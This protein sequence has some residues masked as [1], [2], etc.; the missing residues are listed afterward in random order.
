MY[1]SFLT[2]KRRPCIIFDSDKGASYKWASL[3]CHLLVH[4]WSH[5]VAEAP[6]NAVDEEI[7]VLFCEILSP[8]VDIEEQK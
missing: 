7:C 8:Q 3:N 1:L 2:Q 6:E 5:W 4:F